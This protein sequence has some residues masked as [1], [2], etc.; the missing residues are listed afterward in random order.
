[1]LVN[2]HSVWL[3]KSSNQEV[4]IKS[5]AEVMLLKR[6][7]RRGKGSKSKQAE[8]FRAKKNRE[9]DDE[10]IKKIERFYTTDRSRK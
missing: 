9:F 5:Q 2:T 7:N 8:I 3:C 6:R 4:E 10:L 1:M